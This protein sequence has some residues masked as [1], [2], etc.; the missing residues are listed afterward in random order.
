MVDIPAEL[1]RRIASAKAKA[2]GE[3]YEEISPFSVDDGEPVALPKGVQPSPE[4]PA[5]IP[6]ELLE[7]EAASREATLAAL[8]PAPVRNT[9]PKKVAPKPKVEPLEP[10]AVPQTQAVS[11]THL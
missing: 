7:R 6:E 2:F 5:T 11:Y 10:V 4:A 3:E 9:V 8:P 1:I